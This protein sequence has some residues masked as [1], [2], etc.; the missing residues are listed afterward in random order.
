MN[1]FREKIEKG[2]FVLTGEVAPPKGPDL[3]GVLERAIQMGEWVDAINI[4]DNQRAT[5]KVSNW[6]VAIQMKKEGVEPIVQ[7]TCRD[8]NRLA[9][10]GDLMA[11]SFYQIENILAL[12]GDPLPKG[13][14]TKGVFD[15]TP[16][17]LIQAIQNL[18]EGKDWEGNPLPA[19]TN[20]FVGAVV[21][22][23]ADPSLPQRKWMEKKAQAGARFFQTQAIFLPE[24]MQ[25]FKEEGIPSLPILGGILL[26]KDAL[27]ARKIR[28]TFPGIKI[29][30][31]IILRLE[32]ARDPRETSIEIALELARKIA[33]YVQGIHL[34]SVGQERTL[35]EVARI[36]RKELL[37]VQK[38]AQG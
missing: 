12:T 9:L 23:N 3:K 19:Q 28:E 36:L 34:M 15:F 24:K 10:Q 21:N 6:A 35:T 33:P 26:L 18:N 17:E 29:P 5:L 2:E 8:R 25:K 38:G 14:K 11:L 4:T 16:V 27:T 7:I 22:P 32:K 31:E 30:E 20:L 37:F 13:K 1:P